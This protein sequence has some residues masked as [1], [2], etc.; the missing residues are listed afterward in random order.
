MAV[1]LV[2]GSLS[3]SGN[4]GICSAG[5]SPA[6]GAPI[7]CCSPVHGKALQELHKRQPL[8]G[9]DCTAAKA[10]L[11][12]SAHTLHPICLRLQYTALLTPQLLTLPVLQTNTT[13]HDP[14]PLTCVRQ[15]TRGG[16]DG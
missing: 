13:P 2:C 14:Q 1:C 3:M 5:I 9:S 12:P 6:I 15:R 16:S 4:V 10:R 8:T 11:L 7:D